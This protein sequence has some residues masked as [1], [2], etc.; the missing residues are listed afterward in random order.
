LS[1]LS[2]SYADT[3]AA[4]MALRFH[5][6]DGGVIE[7]PPVIES[8][9]LILQRPE[10]ADLVIPDLARWEDWTVIEKM[11]DLFRSADEKSSWVRVPVI[12]YLRACPLPEAA[13]LLDELKQID[14]VA[15]R[16]AT[17]FFPVPQPSEDDNSSYRPQ[18]HPNQYPQPRVVFSDRLGVFADRP[19]GSRSN[20]YSDS[21]AFS[22]PTLGIPAFDNRNP[23]IFVNQFGL[24]CVLT[25][26]CTTVWLSMW[27]AITGAG[28]HY[29]WL[30]RLCRRLA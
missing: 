19:E 15:F 6:T 3:Y 23:K 7:R 17:Q 27:L 28:T 29:R 11:A 20:H 30:R 5:G 21:L 9:R 13:K 1:N 18:V 22:S 24:A 12:N 14:P 4:I 25:T 8:L 2:S 10:L 26:T 16:R